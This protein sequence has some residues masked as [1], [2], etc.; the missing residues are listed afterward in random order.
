MSHNIRIH[1]ITDIGKTRSLNQDAFLIIEPED[2]NLPDWCELVVAVFDG[3]SG[4]PN[5]HIASKKAAEYFTETITQD[6]TSVS[7]TEQI[8]PILKNI[9]L[10][11]NKRLVDDAPK[12]QNFYATTIAVVLFNNVEP[13]IIHC[14]AV[15]DSLIYKT[16]SE[17][18]N[19][20][21]DKDSYINA[22]RR[23]GFDI[24]KLEASW[25]NVMTQALGLNVNIQPHIVDTPISRGENVLLCTDGLTDSLDLARIEQIIRNNCQNPKVLCEKL[26]STAIEECGED[27][28]TVIAGYVV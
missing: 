9:I 4:I 17:G 15:G 6:S 7:F 25:G 20:I 23:K 22:L 1:G 13:E 2:Q 5:G 27:D 12:D 26:I 8:G 28:T 18:L 3:A 21:F 19:R 10:E 14:G 16:T 24:S 11:T